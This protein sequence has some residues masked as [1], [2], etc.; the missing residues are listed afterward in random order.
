MIIVANRKK[1]QK[2]QLLKGLEERKQSLT[3]LRRND[4]LII[5]QK[6]FFSQRRDKVLSAVY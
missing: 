1:R 3:F 5:T 2:F 6:E 4:I